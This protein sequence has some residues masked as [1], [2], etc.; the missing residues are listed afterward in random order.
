MSSSRF[1]IAG[2][3]EET[4]MPTN[5]HTLKKILIAYSV[6]SCIGDIGHALPRVDGQTITKSRVELPKLNVIGVS[7]QTT[8]D[9]GLIQVTSELVRQRVEIPSATS[10][11]RTTTID[12]YAGTAVKSVTLFDPA[13]FQNT[14]PGT[15][16]GSQPNMYEPNNCGTLSRTNGSPTAT[17]AYPVE[18]S[19]L[20]AQNPLGGGYWLGNSSTDTGAVVNRTVAAGT[21]SGILSYTCPLSP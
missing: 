1:V 2:K 5:C 10:P 20:P 9:G 18:T 14:T 13:S 7:L 15:T 11:T 21:G 6:V 16:I 3:H 17:Y 8:S 4:R 12:T 19:T